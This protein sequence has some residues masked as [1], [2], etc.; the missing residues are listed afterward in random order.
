MESHGLQ[1]KFIRTAPAATVFKS[2]SQVDADVY[3]SII[4]DPSGT[5]TLVDRKV[6]DVWVCL[7]S[8]TDHFHGSY[9]R[10]LLCCPLL[11]RNATNRCARI[12]SKSCNQIP[13]HGGSGTPSAGATLSSCL[14]T[15]TVPIVGP[16][17]PPQPQTCSLKTVGSVF[18]GIRTTTNLKSTLGQGEI[19]MAGGEGGGAQLA[20]FCFLCLF[21]RLVCS[22]ANFVF[23][24][25]CV[26]VALTD[27]DTVLPPPCF[28]SRVP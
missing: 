9:L 5:M 21:R 6:C 7:F 13:P 27:A 23:F 18:G 14:V 26:F 25:F 1:W 8:S 15:R 2:G 20:V 12:P 24:W 4:N 16:S 11:C 3:F 17:T 28:T 19:I 22:R 10:P